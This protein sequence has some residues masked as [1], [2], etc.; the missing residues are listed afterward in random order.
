MEM[1]KFYCISNTDNLEKPTNWLTTF[2]SSLSERFILLEFYKYNKMVA[3]SMITIIQQSVRKHNK[4]LFMIFYFISTLPYY[5][6]IKNN[7]F[8]IDC[9]EGFQY[10]TFYPSVVF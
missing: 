10:K 2:K 9:L 4:H 8:I 5:V 1:K 3:Q 7:P 6:F